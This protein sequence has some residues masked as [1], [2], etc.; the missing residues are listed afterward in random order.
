MSV[1]PYN[2][3]D[4]SDENN[5]EHMCFLNNLH[6]YSTQNITAGLRDCIPGSK[7][8]IFYSM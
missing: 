1:F 4:V 8:R 7:F 3:A 5:F 2:D 6:T